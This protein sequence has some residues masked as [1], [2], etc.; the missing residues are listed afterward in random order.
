M[1]VLRHGKVVEESDVLPLR[2]WNGD[3][4]C[5]VL[6]TITHKI[7]G[8]YDEVII[9]CGDAKLVTNPA[10]DGVT[11]FNPEDSLT[12]DQLIFVDYR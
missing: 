12:I 7:K 11:F 4:N 6:F 5:R 10:G 8:E 2:K 3:S 1:Q 9:H